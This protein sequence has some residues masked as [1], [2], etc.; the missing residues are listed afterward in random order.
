MKN[1]ILDFCPACDNSVGVV[2]GY[3]AQCGYDQQKQI[4]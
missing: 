1:E 3:C 4:L 2:N